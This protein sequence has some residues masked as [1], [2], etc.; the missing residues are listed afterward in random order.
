MLHLSFSSLTGEMTQSP[1]FWIRYVLQIHVRSLISVP[2]FCYYYWPSPVN[3]RLDKTCTLSVQRKFTG[4]GQNLYVLS[5]LCWIS[6]S[7]YTLLV[8]NIPLG[9]WDNDVLMRD[10][11]LLYFG[12]G[13]P[14]QANEGF[15]VC[16]LFVSFIV[17]VP[18]H[19]PRAAW[20]QKQPCRLVRSTRHH[21]GTVGEFGIA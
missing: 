9:A 19:G 15:S 14:V 18:G 8:H 4:R 3:K 12:F 20:H 7:T 10:D 6:V 11:F 13:S 16:S 17:D 1:R 2:C 5:F 21:K